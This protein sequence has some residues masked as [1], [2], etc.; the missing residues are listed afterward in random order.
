[1]SEGKLIFKKMASVLADIGSVG[2]DSNNTAQGYKFRGI[3]AMINALHG[4]LK[5][6][7][8]FITTDVLDK[9]S[10]VR[11]VVR[12]NGKPGYDK[13][14]ELTM[15]YTFHAED[16]SSV[17]SVIAAE[18]LDSGDKATNK[19][20][21]AALK[22]ALIQT[23]QVPTE[24][25]EEAD[26]TSPTIEAPAVAPKKTIVQEIQA[27]S[28]MIDQVKVPPTPVVAAKKTVSFKPKAA[29]K[30]VPTTTANPEP[31]LDL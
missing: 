7:G 6:H 22:Y 9:K 29:A 30:A 5:K 8:V 18:G 1:M 21:S 11:E 10:E 16:G 12:G 23:F 28:A 25:M 13:V 2:K 27:K 14:V 4:A 24:D 31:E 20:L 3:D 15:K 26:L 17:S 19:A